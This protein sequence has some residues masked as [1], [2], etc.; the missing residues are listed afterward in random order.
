[1]L[2]HW[3]YLG[4]TP[5][6]LPLASCLL[7][8]ET[9][10]APR[11]GRFS[12]RTTTIFLDLPSY[13]TCTPCLHFPSLSLPCCSECLPG[14]GPLKHSTYSDSFGP[15]EPFKATFSTSVSAFLFCTPLGH[16]WLPGLPTFCLHSHYTP[17]PLHLC[18]TVSWSSSPFPWLPHLPFP[19]SACAL[20]CWH[21]LPLPSAG[22]LS[23][24]IPY[25][26]CLRADLP[27]CRCLTAG[28]PAPL[29]TDGKVP[30]SALVGRFVMACAAGGTSAA[31]DR[32]VSCLPALR[33]AS[34]LRWTC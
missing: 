4:M 33:A 13:P 12:A 14:L 15:A 10:G 16:C 26:F 24:T 1:M 8:P 31:A 23:S 11:A 22:R 2:R 3:T 34:S 6:A 19:C 18:P 21:F 5:V 32:H 25:S 17:I 29:R 7:T 9:T 28:E 30:S 27:G 20:D